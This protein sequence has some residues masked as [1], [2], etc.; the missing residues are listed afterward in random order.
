MLITINNATYAVLANPEHLTHMPGCNYC[1]FRVGTK[2]T[3]PD[4]SKRAD[5]W[6]PAR[7]A[8]GVADHPAYFVL[9]QE[10]TPI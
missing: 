6:C 9:S 1:A 10:D 8:R 5:I 3:H 7:R 2:C 4:Y